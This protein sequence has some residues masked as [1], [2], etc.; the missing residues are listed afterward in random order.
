MAVGANTIWCTK[1]FMVVTFPLSYP[2]SM[3]LDKILGDEIGT[4]YDKKKLIELL[5]VCYL[6]ALD[7]THCC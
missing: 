5:K 1:F 6:I 4:V 3:L 7:T 2:I